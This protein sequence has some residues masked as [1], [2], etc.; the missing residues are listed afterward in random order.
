MI[1]VK[2]DLRHMFG[3]VRDQGAR[4]TCLVFAASDVHASMRASVWEPLCCEYAY[5]HAVQ[6]SHKDPSR[7]V[8]IDSILHAIR[9]MGQ[10]YEKHWPYLKAIPSDIALW[11]PPGAISPLFRRNSQ[12][13]TDTIADLF[14]CIDRAIPVVVGM[15]ISNAFYRPGQG[16]VIN[17]NEPV[18]HARRHA[19]VGLG[20]GIREKQRHLLI[21]NSWGDSWGE[22]GYAWIS[23]DYL[24][25]RILAYVKFMEDLTN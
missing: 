6:Y 13:C 12:K 20:H 1:T 16:G 18:D 11:T 8:D 23:E 17:S 25:P 14:D 5:Y 10:P 3:G 24:K 21:R 15:T 2:S 19:V 7:G 9:V 22:K 4:P